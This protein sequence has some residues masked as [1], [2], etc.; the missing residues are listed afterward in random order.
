MLEVPTRLCLQWSLRCWTSLWDLVDCGAADVGSSKVCVKHGNCWGS[1]VFEKY[2]NKEL[3]TPGIVWT[4]ELQMVESCAS[5]RSRF[6][7]VSV[8][9]GFV[10]L[11]LLELLGAAKV[12]WRICANQ[13][14]CLDSD[15]SEEPGLVPDMATAH[16]MNHTQRW[17]TGEGGGAGPVHLSY[18]FL[19]V[20]GGG[21]GWWAGTGVRPGQASYDPMDTNS[22]VIISGNHVTELPGTSNSSNLPIGKP[23]TKLQ[24]SCV[25]L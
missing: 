2:G 7:K 19:S 10:E 25:F 22:P 15:D 13:L 17:A 23:E 16:G 24:A 5:W 21:G 1:F 9:C 4:M 18:R 11:Q 20:L 8:F 3:E 6:W 12:G 14:R